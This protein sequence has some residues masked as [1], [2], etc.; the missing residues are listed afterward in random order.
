M[1]S[2]NANNK[3]EEAK[4]QS[5]VQFTNTNHSD[6]IIKTSEIEEFYMKR[7]NFWNKNKFF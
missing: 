7:R 1:N 2:N 6:K 4:Y 3:N 5:I